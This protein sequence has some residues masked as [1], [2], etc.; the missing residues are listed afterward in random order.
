MTWLKKKDKPWLPTVPLIR[1]AE[2]TDQL[3][4]SL[5]PDDLK[6]KA[7]FNTW[8]VARIFGVHKNTILRW[9][10]E[11]RLTPVGLPNGKTRFPRLG[12]QNFL[13]QY[14]QPKP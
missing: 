4:R 6:D 9:V 13:E 1:P 12:L 3:L 8:E 14:N 11:N 5:L 10:K 2:P 7:S